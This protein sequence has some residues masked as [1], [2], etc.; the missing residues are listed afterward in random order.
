MQTTLTVVEDERDR[1]MAKLL[2]EEKARKEL[3]GLYFF[4]Y[5]NST[6]TNSTIRHCI[7]NTSLNKYNVSPTEQ[8]QE[9]EHA[10]ATLK[11]E[12][13]HVENQFK[14]LK[15]KNEIIVEMYQQKESAL[16]Q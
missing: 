12:K 3:E 14:L 13:S 4:L 1:F 11:S 6:N 7:S 16:Q 8:H 5:G 9:L 15:Q 2:N 10:I